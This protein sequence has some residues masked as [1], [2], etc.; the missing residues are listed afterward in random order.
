MAMDLKRAALGYHRKSFGMAEKFLSEAMN[1]KNEAVNN[2]VD[3]YL[4]FIF[5]RLEM[6]LEE[7]DMQKR[8]EETL[9]YSTLIQNYT[10]CKNV[11]P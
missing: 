2:G 7:D 5:Q 10:I 1:R 11:S 4:L 3:S 6:I 9:M 8:A